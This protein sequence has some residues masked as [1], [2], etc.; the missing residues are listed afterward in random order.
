[1]E[2]P[3]TEV[4][5]VCSGVSEDNVMQVLKEELVSEPTAVTETVTDTVTDTVAAVTLAPIA[6]DRATSTVNATGGV[7]GGT[8]GGLF[9]KLSKEQLIEYTKKQKK[10]I[11]KLKA[12]LAAEQKRRVDG[13]NTTTI[14]SSVEAARSSHASSFDL[15]WELVD[16]RPHWQ[17]KLAKVSLTALLS[18]A[19]ARHHAAHTKLQ[20]AFYKWRANTAAECLVQVSS[21]LKEN[22]MTNAHLE[23]RY[24]MPLTPGSHCALSACTHTYTHV[25]LYRY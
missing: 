12:D 7:V 8:G 5:V 14:Q 4:L 11:K 6:T 23:Q 25:C 15:F 19:P 3:P 17:Q 13:P 20:S 10:E 18:L 1:M 22:E 2:T 24:S 9:A 21:A 16:R